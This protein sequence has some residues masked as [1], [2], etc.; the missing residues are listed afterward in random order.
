[1]I[2]SAKVNPYNFVPLGTGPTRTAWLK[3]ITHERLPRDSHSGH[4]I[5]KFRTVTPVFIPSRILA[6]VNQVYQKTT[7]RRFK[8]RNGLPIIP[9]TSLKG[10][11][12]SVFEALTDS[13]MALYAGTYESKTYPAPNHKHSLC[14]KKHGLCP[15]CSVFGII[16]GDEL[17][18]QGKLRFSDAEGKKEHLKQGDWILKELS[19]PKPQRHVPFYAQDGAD[20]KSGPRGRKFYFHHDPNNPQITKGQHNRNARVQERLQAGA[21]LHATVDFQGLTEGEL[22]AL[23]YALELDLSRE[24]RDGQKIAIRTLAHKIGMAK[25]LGLGSVAITITGGYIQRGATRYQSW[26]SSAPVDLQTMIAELKRGAPAPSPEFRDLLSLSKYK[27]ENIEYEY[28]KQEW[29]GENAG[30]RLGNSGIFQQD[31]SD[32]TADTTT[33]NT[34]IEQP[35]TISQAQATVPIGEAPSVKSDEQA[36]WL[37]EVYKDELVLV[38]KEGNEVRRPRRAFQGNATQLQVGKWCILSGTKSVRPVHLR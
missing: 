1:V 27:R 17:L 4:L 28:P 29:F 16:Q 15:A 5:L 34:S 21:I 11:I 33:H 7:F 8:H 10:V 35:S 19:S 6:D 12:R 31:S 22:K 26:T 32:T 20:P 25:P 36:A 13:C 9:A 14:G 38:T 3:T 30:V 37:K 23:L 24:E 2:M 18:L